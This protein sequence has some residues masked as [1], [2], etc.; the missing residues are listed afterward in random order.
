M[1]INAGKFLSFNFFFAFMSCVSHPLM[2]LQQLTVLTDSNNYLPVVLRT[3]TST[4]P[5]TSHST[6]ASHPKGTPLQELI[7]M[8]HLASQIN[9][10][11]FKSHLSNPGECLGKR[12]RRSP[13]TL[14]SGLCCH[15]QSFRSVDR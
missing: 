11:P 6:S 3:L 15:F 10:W 2:L 9:Y 1:D 13:H 8:K 12:D 7:V 5:F 14:Q 4:V